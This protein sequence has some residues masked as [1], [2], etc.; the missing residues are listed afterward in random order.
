MA[1]CLALVSPLHMSPAVPTT[2]I[3]KYLPWRRCC[4]G[5]G[6]SKLGSPGPLFS[7]MLQSKHLDDEYESS[8][9]EREPPVVPP[10]WRASQP[11]LTVRAQMAPR[12]QMGPRPPMA[13]RPQV[14][15]RHV[16]SLPP[17]NVAL[18]QDRVRSLPF[19]PS[20]LPPPPPP[21]LLASSLSSPVPSPLLLQANKLVKYLM[22]KDY[23]KIPIKRSG[24]QLC[25]IPELCP[26]SS[27]SPPQCPTHPHQMFPIIR[28]WPTGPDCAPLSRADRGAAALWPSAQPRCFSSPSPPA[29]MMKDVIREYDEHFPEIIERATYTL[30]KVG[31]VGVAV[32]VG[33]SSVGQERQGSLA[34]RSLWRPSVSPA[35]SASLAW[36]LHLAAPT[37]YFLPLWLSGGGGGRSLV[38]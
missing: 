6:H 9:E 22:I 24:G 38:S 33:D 13:Q 16:L 20:P 11:P 27:P 21:A 31:G 23:K 8:E 28:P 35:C 14:P 10:T 7:P 36:L 1:R 2:L 30:E 3:S 19:A 26:P 5:L 17:R 29:D 12:A 25:P 37:T 18:L 34:P 32:G 15:S 4:Q